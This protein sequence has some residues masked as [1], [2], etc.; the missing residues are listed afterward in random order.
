MSDSELWASISWMIIVG[1]LILV[2]LTL[3]PA[4]QTVFTAVNQVTAVMGN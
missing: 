1:L 2:M 3:L 4:A